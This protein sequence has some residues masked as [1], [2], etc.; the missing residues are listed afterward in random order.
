MGDVEERVSP[1]GLPDLAGERIDTRGV[2]DQV[3]ID[4]L[5][6]ILRGFRASEIATITA[7]AIAGT[8]TAARSA[9]TATAEALLGAGGTWAGGTC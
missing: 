5:R 1:A 4:S 3:G 2:R 6:Q 7:T 8:V 9:A